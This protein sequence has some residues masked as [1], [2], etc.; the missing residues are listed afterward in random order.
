MH[1]AQV[2]NLLNSCTL[3]KNKN[4]KYIPVNGALHLYKQR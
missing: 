2:A 3:C 1:I 4:E